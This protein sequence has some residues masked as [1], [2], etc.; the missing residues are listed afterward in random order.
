MPAWAEPKAAFRATMSAS[1]QE[2]HF[3]WQLYR[4]AKPRSPDAEQMAVAQKPAKST[5]QESVGEKVG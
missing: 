4:M 3:R 2:S 5:E 1:R